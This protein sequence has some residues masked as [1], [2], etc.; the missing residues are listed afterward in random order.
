MYVFNE[1]FDPIFSKNYFFIKYIDCN[2]YIFKKSK[3]NNFLKLTSS[4]NYFFFFHY[5]ILNTKYILNLRNSFFKYAI[6]IIS[7]KKSILKFYS[8]FSNFKFFLKNSSFIVTFPIDI[9]KNPILESFYFYKEFR[10]SGHFYSTSFPVFLFYISINDNPKFNVPLEFFDYFYNNQKTF[11]YCKNNQ[12]FLKII[13][14]FFH[15]RINFFFRK[16]LKFCI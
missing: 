7:S 4:K 3:K 5:N 14:L 13:F 6:T 9:S 15:S 8:P 12:M 1:I 2:S 10:S 16:I 11:D